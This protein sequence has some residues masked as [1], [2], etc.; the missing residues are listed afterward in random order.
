MR[1]RRKEREKRE[2]KEEWNSN[3]FSWANPWI[4]RIFVPAPYNRISCRKQCYSVAF[5]T[6][7]RPPR[8]R[9]RH[10]HTGQCGVSHTS[11]G[12]ARPP[13]WKRVGL[14]QL[15]DRQIGL[16]AATDWVVYRTSKPRQWPVAEWRIN[17]SPIRVASCP[18]SLL[19]FPPRIV[20]PKL[21]AMVNFYGKCDIWFLLVSHNPLPIRFLNCT[22]TKYTLLWKTWRGGTRGRFVGIEKPLPNPD[23][24]RSRIEA[25]V[26]D[27]RNA[28]RPPT[29]MDIRGKF[30]L[31]R[32]VGR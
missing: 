4:N 29:L 2:G 22:Y 10:F 1:L 24:P 11:V 3:P 27:R 8:A 6:R 32:L 17:P 26:A 15:V 12:S 13:R 25:I 30:R 16:E 28:L 19:G 5:F 7:S 9:T 20:A 23:D 21:P 31:T 14:N 18:R